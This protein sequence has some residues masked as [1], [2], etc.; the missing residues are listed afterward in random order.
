MSKRPSIGLDAVVR[1]SRLATKGEAV[2]ASDHHP[3][4][5]ERSE[6]AAAAVIAV[7]VPVT[8]VAPTITAFAPAIEEGDEPK[9]VGNE[10]PL[11]VEAVLA[12]LAERDRQL[13]IAHAALA[14]VEQERIQ[15]QAAAAREKDQ[16]TVAL[17]AANI[18]IGELRER[19][20]DQSTEHLRAELLRLEQ[21][22]ARQRAVAERD[23]DQ[24]VAN[25]AA[26]DATIDELRNRV[27]DLREQVDVAR[28]EV[29]RLIGHHAAERQ[30]LLD[31]HK[32]E[33][34]RLLRAAGVGRVGV[35]A[36]S[37]S[38]PGGVSGRIRRWL[39]GESGE[40]QK[41]PANPRPQSVPPRPGAGAPAKP[42][43][44]KPVGPPT[45]PKIVNRRPV[46]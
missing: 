32:E 42:T 8:S 36:R 38:D 4:P 10:A 43:V 17:T 33:C 5:L 29:S 16:L 27:G 18:T 2:P 26:A 12:A 11:S 6:P 34:E 20:G 28:A 41:G 9:P 21:E 3:D 25:L 31:H 1:K 45:A 22:S 24:W 23:Q 40:S 46:S 30:A 14:R 37:G 44:A 7:S 13:A 35:S 19:I 15:E 39:F